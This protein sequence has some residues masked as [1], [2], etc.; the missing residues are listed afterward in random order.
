M[1]PEQWTRGEVDAR[2]D[3]F[4]FCVVAYEALYGE[5]PFEAETATLLAIEVTR[6]NVRDAPAGSRVPEDLRA[7]LVRGLQSAP[8]DRHPDMQLLLLHL[9]PRRKRVGLAAVGAMGVGVVAFA[10]VALQTDAE[11]CPADPR[12]DELWNDPRR[13]AI[14]AAMESEA[15]TFGASTWSRVEATMG[16]YAAAWTDHRHAACQATVDSEPTDLADLRAA[17]LD[18]S[19]AAFEAL[20]EVFADADAETVAHAIT[21]AANLPALDDCA[22]E[23]RLRAGQRQPSEAQARD[24]VRSIRAEVERA[25]A[26]MASG[27]YER[28]EAVLG[29]ALERA[30]ALG[31]GP[32]LAEI[33]LQR[34]L[35]LRKLGRSEE[36]AGVFEQAFLTAETERM[37]G[38]AIAA[39]LRRA[40]TLARLGKI[41]DAERQLELAEARHEAGGKAGQYAFDML[42]IQ[43]RLAIA[44]G[45]FAGARTWIERQV[46]AAEEAGIGGNDLAD[47][48]GN[49][50]SIMARSGDL[51][52]ALPHGERAVAL[53]ETELG[54]DHPDLARELHNVGSLHAQLGRFD[55]ALP[56][57]ERA[58]EIKRARLRP[59]HPDLAY[60]LVSLGI[61]HQEIGRPEEATTYLREALEVQHASLGP[62]HPELGFTHVALAEL[63]SMTGDLDA[64]L[65]SIREGLRVDEKAW[66]PDDPR[67][68]SDLAL[69]GRIHHERGDS[70][71][72]VR[73]LER[74]LSI[75]DKK[76]GGSPHAPAEARWAL[77]RVLWGQDQDRTR[78]IDLAKAALQHYE[79]PEAPRPDRARAITKWLDEHASTGDREVR[80][81]LSRSSGRR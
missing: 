48:L 4:A 18:R 38:I 20:L 46:E 47:T 39:G 8:D 34:G 56:M 29:D 23:D 3:Q 63:G 76:P 81:A 68:A 43:S 72:A 69:L 6:G 15:G 53:R 1:A 78:A 30:T 42:G 66:G 50:S 40:E 58:L 61:A 12:V 14:A 36:A 16:D 24:E 77:A 37:D 79:D 19:L 13:G 62:D 52:A 11:P 26:W 28:A 55:D 49:L 7:A 45:D 51:A 67:V 27:H 44:R 5:R 9:F 54:P 65:A 22:D 70:A 80:G 33:H 2:T 41:D 60:T 64:A 73:P 32:T 31:W 75:Y 74:A 57:L 10:W 35:V 21:A 25:R 59:Q 17:C 71:S